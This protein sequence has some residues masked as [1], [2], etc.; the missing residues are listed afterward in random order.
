MEYF[1][2]KVGPGKW[3]ANCANVLQTDIHSWAHTHIHAYGKMTPVTTQRAELKSRVE[4]GLVQCEAVH[5]I[6]DTEIR[7]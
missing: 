5:A 3:V 6:W 4:D 1:I 7:V 2:S